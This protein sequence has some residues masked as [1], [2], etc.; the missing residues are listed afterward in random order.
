MTAPG[1]HTDIGT[2]VEVPD[3][4]HIRISGRVTLE[5]SPALRRAI[6][7]EMRGTTASRM[8]LELGGIDRMDT[9]GAAVLAEALKVG[10]TKGM[11]VL[12][13][14]P[15]ESVLRIFRLAGFEEVLAKCCSDREETRQRLL[16]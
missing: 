7:D 9:S 10:Q 1:F 12:L 16:D 8:I 3:T 14:S 4:R 11:R 15:S 6:L 13:C 2:T 5:E